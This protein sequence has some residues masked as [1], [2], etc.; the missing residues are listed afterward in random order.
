MLRMLLQQ[1]YLHLQKLTLPSV[2]NQEQGSI[3][4]HKSE[5]I[6]NETPS[7]PLIKV[8]FSFE[9]NKGLDCK[10]FFFLLHV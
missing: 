3:S 10:I 6:L 9:A 2:K 1:W 5:T 7:F 8:D 4:H